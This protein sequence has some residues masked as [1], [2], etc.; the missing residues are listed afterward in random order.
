MM[1]TRLPA[2]RIVL[3]GVGHTNAHV[4]RMWRM[5]PLDDVE[6]A[7]VSNFPT[8]TYSG[9]LPGVLAGQ[10]PTERMEIDLVRLCAASGARL[11]QA[12]VIGL[13][14]AGQRLLFRDRPPLAFDAL[15]IGVG[16][17]PTFAG[18]ASYDDTLLPIKPMQTFLVRLEERLARVAGQFVGRPMRIA[19][20]GG[21]AAGVE[22][23]FC[24]PGFL[25]ERLRR[26]RHDEP[27]RFEQT[28][29]HAGAELAG[30]MN[31]AA[32]RLALAELKRRGVRVV[33]DG[34][35]VQAAEG[36]LELDDGR[37]LHVDL[38]LWATGA[39]AP[40]LLAEL[41][42]ARDERGFLLTDDT[43]RSVSGAPVF[44][45][46]D[47]GVIAGENLPK[48]GVYAVRQGP[49]L[50]ENLQRTLRGEPMLAYR[51]Q[52]GFLK[53]LNTGDG[54]AI[55]QYAGW[56]LH[57]RWMWQWKDSIDG[58]FMDKFQ[59][60][61]PMPPREAESFAPAPMRCA[62][63]GGKVGASVLANVLSRLELPPSEDV[64]VGLSAPDDAAVLRPTSFP[65]ALTV[66]FFAPPVDDPFLAGRLAALN[67][68]SD[69]FAMGARPRAALAIV[70]LPLGPPHKQEELLHALLAGAL[71]EFQTHSVTL[72]GGHTI[73]GPQLTIGFA[74][75]GTQQC[76]PPRTK[77]RL[78]PG[79][80]LLLTK[81]LGTGALLAAHRQAACRAAWMDSL[82]KSMLQ[83]NSAAAQA[84]DELQLA[85]ATDVTGFGLAGHLLEMLRAS[86]MAARIAL[87]R[88]P[89][90]PGAAEVIA[91][92]IESTLAP[93]NE[94][95]AC[96][97]DAASDVKNLPVYRALFDPQT[98]G[99]MLLGVPAAQADAA[100]ARLTAL[101]VAAVEIG[102]VEGAGRARLAVE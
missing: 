45:V 98:C 59:D 102:A 12:E 5:R 29:V 3:L 40:P 46:G 50:W 37:T 76:D 2:K 55:G 26:L 81:P 15:S 66:D 101:G 23:T 42:L 78:R 72:A 25:R 21:G 43:L 91:A 38:A 30:G 83:S 27:D 60:V 70:T 39:A 58:A 6:L 89:L 16:S 73:E 31:P 57:N 87:G 71:A 33:A 94:A 44:A 79:D 41:D 69:L 34:R 10:Y 19:V 100:L 51:P 80:R 77:D 54:R 14:V 18:V 85:A 93:A 65:T 22:L 68:L 75:E 88:V 97:I 47:S 49:V 7:C 28:L 84:A 13:D 64:V 4:L 67:A 82:V 35:V 61:A 9:M 92:G 24:L 32:Q 52:R 11:V 90:L 17:V 74:V 62:G 48:A 63:C 99:G 53:L 86:G 95:A 56:A 20:V 1:Q 36:V 8:A 96:E